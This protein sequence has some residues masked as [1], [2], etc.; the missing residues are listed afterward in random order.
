[1]MASAPRTRPAHAGPFETLSDDCLA[2]C[3]DGAGAGEQA[4]GAEPLV[5]HPGRV[6]LE[7]AQG[8]VQLVLSWCR[9][10]PA[11]RT[12]GHVPGRHEINPALGYTAVQRTACAPRPDRPACPPTRAMG[13]LRR[14][15]RAQPRRAPAAGGTP[16]FPEGTPERSSPPGDVANAFRSDTERTPENSP[17]VTWRCITMAEQLADAAPSAAPAAGRRD[18][19]RKIVVALGLVLDRAGPVRAVP[20]QRPAVAGAPEHALWRDRPAVAGGRRG[21][22]EGQGWT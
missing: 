7:V 2:A 1:M 8:R 19:T 22:I 21:G 13:P 12:P 3:F 20:G 6:V 17:H 16:H 18:V 11:R 9:A 4:A 14:S 15:R 5:A 10:R